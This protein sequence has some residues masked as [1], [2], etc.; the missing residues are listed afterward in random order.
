MRPIGEN[1][2]HEVHEDVARTHLD[3]DAR[4]RRV[5]GVDLVREAHGLHEVLREL[6]RDLPRLPRVRRGGRVGEH[7]NPGRRELDLA[8]H[9]RQALAG[10][11]H[12]RR[13]ER[14]RD[15]NRPRPQPLLLEPLQRLI[16]AGAAAGNDRLLGRVVVGDPD[17]GEP[18]E[19][20]ADRVRSR[21]DRGHR[22]Q[23]LRRRFEDRAA[24]GLGDDGQRLLA[25]HAGLRQRDV[26]AVAVARHE[27]RHHAELSQQRGE[28]HVRG[29]ERRL[30]GVNAGRG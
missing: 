12:E 24:A 27:L 28:P 15:G 20:G 19:R 21:L 25:Q 18:G 30:G 6:G 4:P 29:P 8:E 13:V 22:P 7:G 9:L 11:S 17:V 1:L 14:A 10:R 5:H 3:E 26:L 23:I 2:A 16:D